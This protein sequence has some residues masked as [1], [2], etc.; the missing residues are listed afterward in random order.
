MSIESIVSIEWYPICTDLH[1]K[2]TWKGDLHYA[3]GISFLRIRSRLVL[4][5]VGVFI[6]YAL[7]LLSQYHSDEVFKGYGEI[8]YNRV[9]FSGI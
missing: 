6:V 3:F 7:W 5:P 1:R 9:T 2:L 8:W 4:Y